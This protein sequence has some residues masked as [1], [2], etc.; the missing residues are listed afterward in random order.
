MDAIKEKPWQTMTPAI[1]LATMQ[2]TAKTY[3]VPVDSFVHWC[4]EYVDKFSQG[5]EVFI[6]W[7]K[8]QR[9]LGTLV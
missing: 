8:A 6:P 3:G 9:E 5:P 1:T 4:D 2:L 7:Y